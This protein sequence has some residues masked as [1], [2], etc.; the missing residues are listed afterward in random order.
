MSNEKYKFDDCD[1][2]VV[3]TEIGYVHLR[4]CRDV[5]EM[6]LSKAD[7]KELLRRIEARGES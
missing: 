2:S 5:D 6:T 7:L 1:I 4:L 3:T